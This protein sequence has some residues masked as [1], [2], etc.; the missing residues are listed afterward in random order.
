MPEDFS[1]AGGGEA[2]LSW[3]ACSRPMR[4]QAVSG[5]RASIQID[6][7]RAVLAVI[8]GLGHGPEAAVA[9][10]LA[11]D[12]VEHH[13]AE[14]ID[15]LLLLVHRELTASRGAAAT[16]AIVDAD[17]GLMHWLGVGN[18]E[19]VL[20]RADAIARPRTLGAFLV[21]GVLGYQLNQLHQ[22]TPVVLQDGDTIVMATDGVRANLAELVRPEQPIER[23]AAEILTKHA[24]TDDDALVVVARYATLDAAAP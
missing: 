17:T 12:V 24:R 18:V 10:R 22:P 16:V 23:M 15:V 5:D 20:V 3:A 4:G 11:T 2:F 8:D 21:G 19:G 13:P 6:G 14:P 9:A 7:S 1:R